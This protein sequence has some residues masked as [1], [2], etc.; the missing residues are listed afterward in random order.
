MEDLESIKARHLEDRIRNR[1]DGNISILE[2]FN[3]EP[4]AEQVES[5][6]IKA[7]DDDKP[8]LCPNCQGTGQ[9]RGLFTLSECY[10]CEG[11][12]LDMSNPVAVI[13]WQRSCMEWSKKQIMQHRAEL[14]QLRGKLALIPEDVMTNY[15][16][17]AATEDFYHDAKIK[18]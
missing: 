14:H 11:V 8:N 6:T 17:A 1:N 4:I 3:F 16:N 9:V 10:L 5:D 13:R 7:S 12:G 18:D 15:M 2:S